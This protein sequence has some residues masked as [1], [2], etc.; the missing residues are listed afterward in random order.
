M[1]ERILNNL[2]ASGQKVRKYYQRRLPS[3]QSKDYYY[4][5]RETPN[6]ET[7]IV[8]YGFI[9]NVNDAKKLKNNYKEYAEA[10]VKA[11]MEYKGL[12]Y[13]NKS[14][15]Q[16]D[17]IVKAGDTLWTIAKS[18]GLS[19]QEL[20]EINNLT[21]NLLKVGQVLKLTNLLPSEIEYIVKV[22]D[23]LYSIAS[24][25]NTT[26][27]NIKVLNNLTSNILK[28]GQVLKLPKLNNGADEEINS[29][30]NIYIVKRGDTLYALAN[31]FNISVSDL[32]SA[33]NLL[34]DTLSVGQTLIIPNKS[35]ENKIYTVQKGDSLYKIAESNG[36]TVQNL[37]LLNNLDS[38]I[39]SIG[40][41]L[42]LP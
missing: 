20:K 33:N 9:D 29:P 32:K 28:V 7:V 2:A 22:G 18:T 41:K 16:T 38:D 14:D 11:V 26:V 37:K 30:E 6:A 39:L 15:N 3:N 17:Y 12:P 4:I 36:T 25:Y 1:A 31:F 8:E 34:S 40:Q 27:D 5:I 23:T 13:K 35:E 24:G 10:V 42:L 21:S 19:V